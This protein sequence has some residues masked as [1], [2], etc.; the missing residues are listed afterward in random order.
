MTATDEEDIL[1]YDLLTA[2]SVTF[3][4]SKL[5]GGSCSYELLLLTFPFCLER[6][7]SAVIIALSYRCYIALLVLALHGTWLH[8]WVLQ[9]V[10]IENLRTKRVWMA[11]MDGFLATK[12]SISLIPPV[13]ESL[14]KHRIMLLILVALMQSVRDEARSRR[15]LLLDFMGLK[16]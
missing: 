1:W 16:A 5:L 13:R 2:Q 4:Y 12:I 7:V 3:T 6:L 15:K 9:G 8:L 11:Q 14:S 10:R